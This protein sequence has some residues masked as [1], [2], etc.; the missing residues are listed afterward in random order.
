MNIYLMQALGSLTAA[1]IIPLIVP[2]NTPYWITVVGIFA[3]AMLFNGIIA[4][5]V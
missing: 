4:L 5:F 3:I 2:F 1:L